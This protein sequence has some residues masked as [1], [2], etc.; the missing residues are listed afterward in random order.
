MNERNK[1]ILSQFFYFVSA[2]VESSIGA[3][4]R[5]GAGAGLQQKVLGLRENGAQGMGTGAVR[6]DGEIGPR[7]RA[8]LEQSLSAWVWI[9]CRSRL[10][11]CTGGFLEGHSWWWWWRCGPYACF[12]ASF[13]EVTWVCKVCPQ[14]LQRVT[15]R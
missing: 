1:L 11:R 12:S 9:W 13:L 4:V 5:R 15:Q 8:S 7:R 2:Q 14:V 6:G 3:V 10:R